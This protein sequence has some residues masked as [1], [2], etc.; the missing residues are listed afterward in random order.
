MKSI[1]KVFSSDRAEMPSYLN[2][3]DYNVIRKIAVRKVTKPFAIP[4]GW[5]RLK[6]QEVIRNGDCFLRKNSFPTGH[7]NASRW[8]QC[9]DSVSVGH[10]FATNTWNTIDP[11][12]VVVIRRRMPR[13]TIKKD[14]PSKEAEIRLA[15]QNLKNILGNCGMIDIQVWV[16]AKEKTVQTTLTNRYIKY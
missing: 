16:T 12:N 1:G 9:C 5:R 13:V 6:T 4:D 2:S 7:S 3:T 8:T 11:Q 15:V 10:A 14:E